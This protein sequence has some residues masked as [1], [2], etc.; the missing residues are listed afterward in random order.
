MCANIQSAATLA[1]R[2]SQIR[3]RMAAAAL[4]AARQPEQVSLLAVSKTHPPEMVREAATA[5][6]ID[7]GENKVQEAEEKIPQVDRYSIRWH[8]IGHL[9]SN[10]ARKAVELFD[11]IHSLDSVALARRLE[12]ICEQDGREQLPALIQV[13]LGRELTKSGVTEDKLP[14]LI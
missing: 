6:V 9:Q 4:R 3:M 1:E 13:D 10:K 8:L 12:R 7:F 2:I 11:V 5:G 14:V